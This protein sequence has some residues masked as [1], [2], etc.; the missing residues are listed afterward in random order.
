MTVL[1]AITH[2]IISAWTKL[3]MVFLCWSK[4]EDEFQADKFAFDIGFGNELA[5]VL[6]KLQAPQKSSFIQALFS[7]HPSTNERIGRLQSYGST[8]SSY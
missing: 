7:S 8:Y 1:S 4:R 2:F 5:A 6:D 3:S